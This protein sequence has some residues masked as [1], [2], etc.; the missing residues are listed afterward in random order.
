MSCPLV[1]ALGQLRAS[2]S[3][4]TL[5]A[6]DRAVQRE[7]NRVRCAWRRQ[8]HARAARRDRDHA[9]PT[10][11]QRCPLSARTR[12]R[13]PCT[14]FA[15]DGRLHRR[16]SP[17][18]DPGASCCLCD[19]CIPPSRAGHPRDAG[20]FRGIDPCDEIPSRYRYPSAWRDPRRRLAGIHI[21]PVRRGRVPSRA[22]GRQG[23]APA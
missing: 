6:R 5:S 18:C 15:A 3:A 10:C 9:W 14:G 1:D 11:R 2:S 20:F 21:H 17:D 13:T 23:G 7:K 12:A 19:A 16:S 22:G 4:I 8:G